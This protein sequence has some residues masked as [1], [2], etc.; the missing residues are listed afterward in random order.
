MDCTKLAHMALKSWFGLMVPTMAI[1]ACHASY[2]P[3]LVLILYLCWSSYCTCVGPHIVPV[4][5]LIMYLCWSSYCT[6]VGPHIVPVLVLILYCIDPRIV[7]VCSNVPCRGPHI[8]HVCSNVPCR[9][10]RIVHVCSNVPCRGSTSDVFSG[11]MHPA[12]DSA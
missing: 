1:R 8:V 12:F 11:E 2:V 7:H 5:D 3:L 6:C 10:P 4:F 9:G